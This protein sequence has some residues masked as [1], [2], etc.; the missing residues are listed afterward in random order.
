VADTSDL[1]RLWK[2][3]LKADDFDG[4]VKITPAGKPKAA[5]SSNGYP[6]S[7]IRSSL[8]FSHARYSSNRGQCDRTMSQNFVEGSPCERCGDWTP[9][10]RTDRPGKT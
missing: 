6:G 8:F 2:K 1:R 9:A 7:R 3:L 4:S 10:V 5:I